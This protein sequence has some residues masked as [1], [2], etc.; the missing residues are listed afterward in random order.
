MGADLALE[1]PKRRDSYALLQTT[2]LGF[3]AI[4]RNEAALGPGHQLKKLLE[5]GTVLACNCQLISIHPKRS[6]APSQSGFCAEEMCFA[7]IK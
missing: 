6:S 7:F 2:A 3:H 1:A 5:M 4:C